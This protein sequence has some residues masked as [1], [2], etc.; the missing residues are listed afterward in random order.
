M[1]QNK[2][3]LKNRN[4]AFSE[5]SVA[6]DEDRGEKAYK[7]CKSISVLRLKTCT[8]IVYKLTSFASATEFLIYDPAF[9]HLQKS[10]SHHYCKIM[11]KSS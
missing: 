7:Q 11:Q 3:L 8:F 1:G 9:K 10:I 4:C 2:K 5:F 6:S